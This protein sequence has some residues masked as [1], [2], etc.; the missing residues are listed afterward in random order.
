MNLWTRYGITFSIKN[1]IVGGI[2]TNEKLIEGWVKANMPD[3]AA[4]EREKIAQSTV[5]DLPDLT[6]ERAGM[7][8]TTFKRDESGIFIE[9]RQVKSMFKESA[10][11]LRD[12]LVKADKKAKGDSGK[13]RF[14]N[15]RSKLAERL[16]VEE[17]KIYLLRDNKRI[18]KPDGDEERA[19]H[20]VTAM[21]PR[22]ALKRYDFVNAPCSLRFCVRFIDDGIVDLELINTLLEHA[23]WN[24]LG[25]DRSQGNGLFEVTE[26]KELEKR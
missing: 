7:M 22:T 1:R 8:W 2:P 24:G 3:A 12:L 15:L 21:G 20:V 19:I 26:V 9:G 4:E 10:N 14:T 5:A 17:D 11:I 18:E 13:S 16:F 6:E 25:T 23:S